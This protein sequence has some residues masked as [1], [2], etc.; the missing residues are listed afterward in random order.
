MFGQISFETNVL[1]IVLRAADISSLE[2][3]T[4]ISLHFFTMFLALRLLFRTVFKILNRNIRQKFLDKWFNV[5]NVRET[6]P[7]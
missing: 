5:L 1:K 6:F 3:F 7:F 2:I 4:L